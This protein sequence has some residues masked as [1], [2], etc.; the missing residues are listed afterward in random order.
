MFYFW[1]FLVDEVH[2][3]FER[4]LKLVEELR[5]KVTDLKEKLAEAKLALQEEKNGVHYFQ[6]RFRDI[7]CKK[8]DIVS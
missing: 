5:V 6:E 7:L 1:L 4:R 3:E 8:F 2:A